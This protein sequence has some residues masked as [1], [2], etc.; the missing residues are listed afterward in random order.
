VSSPGYSSAGPA[1]TGPGVRASEAR[2]D[3]VRA[4]RLWGLPAR[5]AG[6]PSCSRPRFVGDVL[7]GSLRRARGARHRSEESVTHREQEGAQ[8]DSDAAARRPGASDESPSGC[9]GASRRHQFVGLQQLR[10]G[11]DVPGH[12]AL[13]GWT[14]PWRPSRRLPG[15]RWC[16]PIRM[17]AR[18][19]RE[20]PP[21][22]RTDRLRGWRANQLLRRY[23]VAGTEGLPIAAKAVPWARPPGRVS[24]IEPAALQG[25]QL[26]RDRGRARRSAPRCS[27][28]HFRGT[29]PAIPSPA[30]A[31]N[32]E[33]RRDAP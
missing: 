33:V 27:F 14:F 13:H 20:T 16:E 19:L 25:G 30:D 4:T 32:R 10:V 3:P 6:P 1:S 8:P 12:V 2:S 15:A 17:P 29:S 21:L 9:R 18:R 23:W 26:R 24:G 11:P 5:C 31:G 7:A 28:R 22:S